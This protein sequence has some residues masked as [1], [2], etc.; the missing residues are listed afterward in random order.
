MTSTGRAFD[1]RQNP[2]SLRPEDAVLRQRGQAGRHEAYLQGRL[3]TAALW[4][5]KLRNAQP[6][7]PPPPP[8]PCVKLLSSQLCCG[9]RDRSA[10]CFQT[11]NR[12]RGVPLLL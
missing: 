2:E 3:E 9:S 6:S 11:H 4:F 5:T 10:E 12:A 8:P 1:S 7:A